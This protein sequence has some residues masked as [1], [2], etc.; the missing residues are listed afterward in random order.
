MTTLMKLVTTCTVCIGLSGCG[1]ADLGTQMAGSKLAGQ[2]TLA[3][4]QIVSGSTVLMKPRIEDLS[5]NS[6]NIRYIEIGFGTGTPKQ[7]R[8]MAVQ[9]CAEF[10]K[11]A[12][13]KAT[14]RGMI[15]LNTV[16]AYYECI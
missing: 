6:F 15:Q 9:Q 7:V 11:K 16:K 4:N 10:G 14:S 8:D 13:Y 1:G 3:E 2:G 5:S 12:V